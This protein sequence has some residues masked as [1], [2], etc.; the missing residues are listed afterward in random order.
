M[1]WSLELHF[2]S[3]HVS[4][5]C[6][7]NLVCRRA[8]CSFLEWHP[9]YGVISAVDSLSFGSS[10]QQPLQIPDLLPCLSMA[11]LTSVMQVLI[12][13]QFM[14]WAARKGRLR[15]PEHCSPCLAA[16]ASWVSLC[17]WQSQ[18]QVQC[19]SMTQ[20][21]SV[22]WPA[23]APGCMKRSELGD[24]EEEAGADITWVS[25]TYWPVEA[26]PAV[27]R[28]YGAP[29]LGL[30]VTALVASSAVSPWCLC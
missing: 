18:R 1:C 9:G 4:A 10:L 20:E 16:K 15:W 13:C 22:A 11:S 24:R 30:T 5:V 19:T 21:D 25:K 28:C 23:L 2:P 29:P 7:W 3:A 6:L 14:P 17:V 26:C 27:G 12:V 8:A